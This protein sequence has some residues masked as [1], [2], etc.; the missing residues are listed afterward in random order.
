MKRR[1]W[2]S[3]RRRQISILL[4]VTILIIFAVGPYI[5]R[6]E[7]LRQAKSN[8]D[9]DKVQD[10]LLW[11]EKHAYLLN[12]LKLTKETKL[13]LELNLGS[14]DVEEKL[15]SYQDKKHQFWFAIYHLQ[16]GNLIEVENLLESMNPS[17]RRQLGKGF[18]SLVKGDAKQTQ[19]LLT[20]TKEDWKSM[21]RQE[22]CVRHL[23]LAQAALILE[24]YPTTK[25]ELEVAQQLDP[26][27]PACLSVEFDLALAQDQWAKASELSQLIDVQAWRPQNSLYQTKKAVLAIHETNS[28]TLSDS[29]TLLKEHPQ[30]GAN[31]SYVNGIIALKKGQLHEGKTLLELALKK[32]LE[33]GV[34]VDAQKALKQVLERQ[35]AEQVLRSW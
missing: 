35:S 6:M 24:D 15:I 2:N 7:S 10:E 22:Q 34:Q 30:G 20:G 13:W 3:R 11:L 12:K 16:A 25:I 21:T 9:V 29:L 31:I 8:Y 18:L 32:G 17:P 14:K 33:G 23:T 19:E 4:F 27:N 1:K 28:W 5:F 26:N